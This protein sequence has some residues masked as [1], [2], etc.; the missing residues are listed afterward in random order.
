MSAIPSIICQFIQQHHVVSL[1]CH[2]QQQIWSAS[3]FYA[4]DEKQH[5]L[6]LLTQQRTQHGQMMA[7]FPVV[8]GTI[9]G[10]PIYIN[11]IEG[12]QFQATARQLYQDEKAQALFCYCQRHPIANTF[13][14]DVWELRLSR[15][16]Y[17]S[18]R[19]RFAEKQEWF[20]Q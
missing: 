18:N 1:A 17:T 9:A 3:C 20:A 6:I 4:F 19:I 10:Q 13:Q 5:R 11:D 14:S 12:V 7:A 16:K 8:A 2:N 15:I